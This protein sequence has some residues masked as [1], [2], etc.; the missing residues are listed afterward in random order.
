MY[1][2][3]A[4]GTGGGCTAWHQEFLLE[5]GQIVHLM[6]T[7]VTGTTHKISASDRM[8]VGVYMDEEGCAQTEFMTWEQD[9]FPL[10]LESNLPAVSVF[11]GA[12]VANNSQGGGS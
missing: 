7:D 10:D 8:V 6:I 12:P 4:I 1:G 3:S 11:P 5:D 9:N 2:F